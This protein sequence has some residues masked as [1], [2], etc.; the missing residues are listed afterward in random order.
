VQ[1]R[2]V[3]LEIIE[4]LYPQAINRQI[5]ISLVEFPGKQLY[6]ITDIKQLKQVVLNLLTNAIKYNIDEGTIKITIELQPVSDSVRQ[7]VRISVTD[8]GPGIL[9][10]DLP[11]I[12]QPFER[13]GAEKSDVEGTG[14]GLSVVKSLMD[15]MG[16]K[17]GVESV[18]G[19][20][21]T[22]WIE[23]PSYEDQVNN[24][25]NNSPLL[26]QELISPLITGTIL[27]IEDNLSHIRL[28]ENMLSTHRPGI[29][30]ITN[31]FGK[32][33]VSLAVEHQPDLVLLDLNLPDTHGS[34]VLRNLK[35][36]EKTSSI[37]VIIISADAMNA[38]FERQ[39]IAGANKYLTKPIDI[40][41][42]LKLID[43]NMI[44]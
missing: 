20:G 27:Y 11:K 2:L 40:L 41:D 21:S 31:S 39:I 16:G 17:V 28:V 42:T 1:L 33:A 7:M 12:F 25:D 30:L 36:N 22:F 37:P 19:E 23:V 29:K 35:S 4:T 38:Q 9:P 6:G 15:A 43:E 32:L 14:L 3:V 8:T 24:V 18:P 10:E 13:I 5:Q 34:S 26:R 44:K